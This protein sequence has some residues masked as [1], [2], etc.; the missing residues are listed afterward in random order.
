MAS[1]NK[2]QYHYVGQK[3][4]LYKTGTDNDGKDILSWSRLSVK[5]DTL[6]PDG[7]LQ[8]YGTSHC[9]IYNILVL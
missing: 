1:A 6:Y 5:I 3:P 2:I 4:Y 7:H 9:I 8:K